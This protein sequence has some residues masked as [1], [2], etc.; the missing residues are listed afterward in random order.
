MPNTITYR[1]GDVLLVPFPCTDQS[2]NKKRP[3]VVVSSAEY[4]NARPDI[5]VMPITAQLSGYPRLGEV[6]VTD[7]KVAA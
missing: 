2:A 7:W 6:I 5:I 3:A 1:F 4:N